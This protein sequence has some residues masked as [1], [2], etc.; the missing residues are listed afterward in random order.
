MSESVRAMKYR[1]LQFRK[2]HILNS[3]KEFERVHI[4]TRVPSKTELKTLTTEFA[5]KAMDLNLL[6]V[7][8]TSVDGAPETPHP[9]NENAIV[10]LFTSN[11]SLQ[12]FLEQPISPS[13][14]GV[15]LV[16]DTTTAP[17]L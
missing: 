16:L 10:L 14:Q 6:Y 4:G 15:S 3:K 9:D 12:E 17:R 7:G 5:K 8:V 11:G 2:A 13:M 1:D